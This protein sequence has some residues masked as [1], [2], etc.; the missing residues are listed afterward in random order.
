MAFGRRN[1]VKLDPLAYNLLLMGESGIGKTT[2]IKE[3]CEKLAGEDGY[4]FLEIGKEDG[5][6]AIEGIVYEPCED[7]TKFEEVIDD[8]VENRT[9]VYSNLKVVV[10]DTYDELFRIA[11]PEVIRMHNAENPENK[12]RPSPGCIKTLLIPGGPGV[13]FDSAVYQG[14]TIPPYYDSMIGKLI[15]HGE[16]RIEAIAKMKRA[17]GELIIDGI[18]T[19]IDFQCAIMNYNSFINGNFNT[20]FIAKFLAE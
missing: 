14:Y 2:I 19:N 12:F 15:V 11:E 1:E 5:A 4:L 13:R 3:Y 8:I 10:I 16:S 9:S 18:D 7:W 17:L 20:G 6:D